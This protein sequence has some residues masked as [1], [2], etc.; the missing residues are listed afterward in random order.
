MTTGFALDKGN[1]KLLGV[2]AGLARTTGA[3][4]LGVR[5]IVAVLSFFL[6]LGVLIYFLVAWLAE[7]R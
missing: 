5:V 4:P 2:C 1:A 3:D 6:P 7:S